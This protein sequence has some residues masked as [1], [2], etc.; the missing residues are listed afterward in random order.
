M[1]ELKRERERKKQPRRD[2]DKNEP[3]R[4]IIAAHSPHQVAEPRTPAR[5]RSLAALWM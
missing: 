1:W 5:Q 2:A 4:A 3:E